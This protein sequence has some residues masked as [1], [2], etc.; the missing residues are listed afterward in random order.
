MGFFEAEMENY[1]A[2]L[3]EASLDSKFSSS[4]DTKSLPLVNCDS[5]PRCWLCCRK[6]C[7]KGKWRAHPGHPTK[8]RHSKEESASLSCP[9]LLPY[10]LSLKWKDSQSAGGC[11]AKTFSLTRALWISYQLFFENYCLAVSNPGV[12]RKSP[13]NSETTCSYWDTKHIC[14]KKILINKVWESWHFHKDLMW[15]KT[16]PYCLW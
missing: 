10:P 9:S 12:S 3:Y 14:Q 15:H 13:C 16:P 2:Q 5:S 4:L 11:L 7:L 8:W 6:T 1:A